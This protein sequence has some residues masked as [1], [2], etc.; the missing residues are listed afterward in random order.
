MTENNY[1]YTR[2]TKF[3]LFHLL[4]QIIL[5]VSDLASRHE[6]VTNSYV[7]VENY[8]NSSLNLMIA[9]KDKNARR[10]RIASVKKKKFKKLNKN[11]INRKRGKQN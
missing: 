11:F 10:H 9:E 2:T 4:V 1:D 8:Q 6:N 7:S 5:I 3:L